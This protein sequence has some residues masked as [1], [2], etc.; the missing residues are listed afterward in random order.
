MNEQDPQSPFNDSD[1]DFLAGIKLSPEVDVPESSAK[2]EASAPVSESDFRTPNKKPRNIQFDAETPTAE[3]TMARM[4]GLQPL[5]PVSAAK[6]PSLAVSPFF[7]PMERLTPYVDGTI[8]RGEV[9]IYN[10]DSPLS[11]TSPVVTSPIARVATP[12]RPTLAKI[13]EEYTAISKSIMDFLVQVRR[14][15]KSGQQRSNNEIQSAAAGSILALDALLHKIPSKHTAFIQVVTELKT[16]IEAN[17]TT[18]AVVTEAALNMF[19]AQQDKATTRAP[20]TRTAKK[21]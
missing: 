10:V 9:K 16:R 5:T 6:T 2:R 3:Q 4:V 17:I 20:S 12:P 8:K 19:L 15:L 21:L 7:V 13:R 11:P 1:D 14:E 18:P